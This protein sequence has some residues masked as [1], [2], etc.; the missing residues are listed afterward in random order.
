MAMSAAAMQQEIRGRAAMRLI[1]FLGRFPSVKA[2][3]LWGIVTACD[4]AYAKPTA[5]AIWVEI[6]RPTNLAFF[7]FFSMAGP[8]LLG[9][10]MS[11]YIYIRV[12]VFET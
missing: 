10:Y 3:I 1:G 5:D 4:V 9:G 6:K 2:L 11:Q 8:R 12:F 7:V